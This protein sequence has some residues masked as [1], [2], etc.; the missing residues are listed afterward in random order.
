MNTPRSSVASRMGLAA[1][2]V[3][4]Q[5]LPTR[6]QTVLHVARAG[7]D[8]WSGRLEAPNAALSDGPVAT[9]ARARD[10]VRALERDSG[11][12]LKGPVTIL[13]H[14]GVYS[15]SEP[16][17][18]TSEDSGDADH[19]IT[20]ASAAGEHPV[21]SA[22]RRLPR[23][24]SVTLD[25]KKLW[26]ADIQ[27][28]RTSMKM[29]RWTFREL[30]VNNQRRTRAR[31]PDVGYLHIEDIPDL[32]PDTQWT[33][34]KNNFR[35]READAT[36]WKK[37]AS[38]DLVVFTRWIDTHL[39]VAGI[40]LE[41]RIATF[42]KRTTF[43]LNPGDL[44]FL[45][46]SAA[47]LDSP[48]EWFLDD[49]AGTI[50]Y[51]PLPG[52]TIDHSIAAAPVFTSVLELHGEPEQGRFVQHV[53]FEGLTFSHAQ[54]W[55]PEEYKPGRPSVDPMGFVQAAWGV[56]GAVHADGAR[57]VAF[58][59]C[60]ISHVGG[61]G[62]E[63]ARG[64]TDDVFSRCTITDL[65]AGGVKIG[66]TVVRESAAD[67]TARNT[68]EDCTLTDGG[69]IHHQA[70]GLWIGQSSENRVTHNRITEFDYSGI[71]IGWTWGYG[72][73]QAGGNIVELNEIDHL[74]DRPGNTE[75]PLGD[76]GG[77]YTLGTQ[78]GTVIRNNFF[79]DIAGRTIA[80]GI[81]FDEG[82]T[83]I[84]A[85]NNLVLRTTH[86]GFHQHYGKE[87]VVQNNIFAMGRD[88][89]VWRTR[90]E[91]HTSFTFAR[92][93]VVAD[94]DKWFN[95]DWSGGVVLQN[96]L[97]W[98][99]DAKPVPFPGGKDLSAWLATG[100]DTGSVV[101]DPKLDLAHPTH[102]AVADDS[103]ARALGFQ[104]FELATVGPRPKG[105]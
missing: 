96:N 98:R 56:P 15:L 58:I 25:G 90:R 53:R 69:H 47:F 73:S 1:L 8:T 57:H 70:I 77:I 54:W 71:S 38:A 27:E 49:K 88:A 91:E 81:Y 18:L 21:L 5:V 61:Y 72:P 17:V 64:C 78:S 22:G 79:H 93:I 66:E 59:D 97:Y 35:F 10:L 37:A 67:R 46:G 60:T 2:L 87:N 12:A 39:T 55:F 101:A 105:P 28:I 43:L 26:S 68:V 99:T 94:N 30:Y 52:E 42:T 29:D 32:P 92:N 48:G 33:D 95:G 89:Q 13:L 41:K 74:G 100:L 11:G 6:Q 4:A 40:D 7:S 23:W 84:V 80:W 85:E 103:P 45:E 63:L 65:G 3:P 9:V 83:G 51:M 14:D 62:F 16:L 24:R 31:C 86:G 34:G 20:Y 76:M 44:Y 50:Y 75:P 19:P 104:P 82:S 102:F 36:V